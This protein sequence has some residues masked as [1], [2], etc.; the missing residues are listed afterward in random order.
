MPSPRSTTGH[1]SLPPFRP[2]AHDRVPTM[3]SA[4]FCGAV[5]EDSSALSPVPGHPADLPWSPVRP[6][7]HRRPIV[8]APS[9]CGW[10]ALL[11]RASSPRRY[12]TSYRVRVPRPARWFHAAFRPHLAVTPLRFPCPSAP[13]ILGQ[14]TCTPKHDR[15]HGTHAHASAAR[16]CCASADAV[17][18]GGLE[19]VLDMLQTADQPSQCLTHAP[20]PDTPTY[21]QRGLDAPREGS[22]N[23]RPS[24]RQGT[25]W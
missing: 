23:D 20:R 1:D 11:S 6:S 17:V 21:G 9:A 8:Q 15:M 7:V 25:S 10:R 16:A 12:H 19:L 18:R 13:R 5:R 22:T 4:D 2:S 3:P 24:L 14:G